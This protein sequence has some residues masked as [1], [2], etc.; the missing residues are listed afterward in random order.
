MQGDQPANA[1]EA[2]RLG[3]GAS[4]PFQQISE[5]NLFDAIHS[6][7]NDPKYT[8]RAKE[9][10]SLAVD[11]IEHPLERATWWLEHIMRHPQEYIKKSPVHRLSWYQYFCIDVLLT[12][13]V[14][15]SLTF[16]ILHKIISLCCCSRK[17]KDKRE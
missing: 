8:N 16:Y 12:I 5:I 15:I 1:K 4:I 17:Q 3:L 13:V 11:Q 2:V 7:I 9:L 10:G 6:T 14:I